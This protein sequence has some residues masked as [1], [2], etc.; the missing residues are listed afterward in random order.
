MFRNGF[1]FGTDGDDVLSGRNGT[2]FIL[3][4][5]GDDVLRGRGG[6]D[7]LIGGEGQDVLYGGNGADLLFG[8]QGN[9]VV[10]GDRARDVLSGGDGEDDLSGGRG[11]DLLSGGAGNDTLNGGAGDDFISGGEGDNDLLTGGRGRD[12]FQ[13]T[14]GD[15]NGTPGSAD[16]I[17]D[18][19]VHDDQFI[20]DATSF[21]LGSDADVVFQNV[22]RHVGAD[23]QLDLDDGL[24]DINAEANVY[25]L[26][27]AFANAGAA[28][29]AIAEARIEAQGGEQI[30]GDQS[31]FFI[32]FNEDQGRN[33]LFAVEDLNQMDGPLQQIVNLGDL[34]PE[35]DM[36]AR[37]DALAQLPTFTADSFDFGVDP[38]A[39]L[40]S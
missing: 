5:L 21:G 14:N 13:F 38:S 22:E 11:A 12:H 31:G 24:A 17:Q 1:L 37:A 32:Y 8:G 7:V 9:D 36:A 33:R 30:E 25:V 10:F 16:Q 34:V 26:Q 28:R 39:L 19:D 27:G 29:N 18:F 23:G 35:S 3:G 20:L 4:G 2:D 15:G 6:I 40:V